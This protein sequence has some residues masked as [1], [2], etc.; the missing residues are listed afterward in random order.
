[1]T[2]G[3]Q[4]LTAR[5]AWFVPDFMVWGIAGPGE[6]E[7]LALEKIDANLSIYFGTANLDSGPQEVAFGDLTDHRGN[8]L[9]STIKS[10]RI[11][12]RSRSTDTVF[13]VG[14]ESAGS[15]QIAR[16]PQATRPVPVDLLIV[17]MGD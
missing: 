4:T 9:P 10:P 15:F 16:D 3:L 8:S 5:R 2:A 13:V 7:Y 11:F 17:E 6:L 1:M 12:P 14:S